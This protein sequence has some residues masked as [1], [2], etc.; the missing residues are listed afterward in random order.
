MTSG[1]EVAA[2]EAQQVPR[3]V[4]P[5][6]QVSVFRQAQL[7]PLGLL[8]RQTAPFEHRWQGFTAR[9]PPLRLLVKSPY[10]HTVRPRPR[11]GPGD[12]P[13]GGDVRAE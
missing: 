8:Q 5:R 4:P 12:G 13:V 10:I 11:T 2:L 3:P 6:Q 7:Q 9:Q 1:R